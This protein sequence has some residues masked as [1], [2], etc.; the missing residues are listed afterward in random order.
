M[1]RNK[2]KPAAPKNHEPETLQLPAAEVEA[3]AVARAAF[4]E[5]HLKFEQQQ[6]RR[7]DA[8]IALKLELRRVY[9]DNK[10]P[11]SYTIEAATGKAYPQATPTGA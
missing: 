7:F 5:E 2:K 4:D 10:I 3:L 11:Q 6:A 9:R 1:S 8:E